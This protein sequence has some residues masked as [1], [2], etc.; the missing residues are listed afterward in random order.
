MVSPTK[1][2]IFVHLSDFRPSISV[3]RKWGVHYPNFWAYIWCKDWSSCRQCFHRKKIFTFTGTE[4]RLWEY[5]PTF[6]LSFLLCM[7]IAVFNVAVLYSLEAL[8]FISAIPLLRLRF[9]SVSATAKRK[10]NLKKMRKVG[11]MGSGKLI[12]T[13]NSNLWCL[14]AFQKEIRMCNVLLLL[15]V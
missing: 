4:H 9:L 7:L 13:W 15:A 6:F 11:C 5:F 1:T 10:R 14:P 12:N 2:Y 8:R 3:N